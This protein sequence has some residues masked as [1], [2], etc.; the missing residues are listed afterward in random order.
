[1]PRNIAN[2]HARRGRGEGEVQKLHLRTKLYAKL[3]TRLWKLRLRQRDG[4]E[5]EEIGVSPSKRV[6][7]PRDDL[8]A[9]DKKVFRN[10]FY[11]VHHVLGSHLSRVR[12]R[13]RKRERKYIFLLLSH[14][15]EPRINK[16]RSARALTN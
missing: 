7:R 15:A 13:E 6:S 4:R 11:R 9:I 16:E 1:M 3:E 12:I 14:T 10:L 5:G 2:L 8:I